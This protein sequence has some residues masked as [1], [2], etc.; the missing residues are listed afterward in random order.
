MGKGFRRTKSAVEEI[1]EQEEEGY[2][3]KGQVKGKPWYTRFGFRRHDQPVPYAG[4][5]GSF[6]GANAAEE[7]GLRAAMGGDW[8]S[9]GARGSWETQ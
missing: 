9:N 3:E 7:G 8:N 6:N 2:K 5:I 4:H 1:R